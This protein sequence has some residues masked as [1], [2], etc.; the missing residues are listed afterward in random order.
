MEVIDGKLQVRP[1]RDIIAEIQTKMK[2][3]L[4]PGV[5]GQ[6][7]VDELIADRRAEAERE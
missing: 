5:T 3:Y 4:G 7:I 2:A 1:Y 6:S